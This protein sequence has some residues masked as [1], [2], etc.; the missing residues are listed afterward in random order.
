MLFAKWRCRKLALIRRRRDPARYRA[1]L[2]QHQVLRRETPAY[3][4]IED[5]RE[6]AQEQARWR[7]QRYKE[8]RAQNACAYWSAVEHPDDP[9]WT[10]VGCKLGQ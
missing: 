4:D 3:A 10:G 7:R 2:K 5:E 6:R 8:L 9:W 1:L